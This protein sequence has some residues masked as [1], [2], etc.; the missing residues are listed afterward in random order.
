[1]EL[2]D[3]PLQDLQKE[4]ISLTPSNS[5]SSEDLYKTTYIREDP[6]L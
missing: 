4:R 5:P 3:I 1:M 2:L 6:G